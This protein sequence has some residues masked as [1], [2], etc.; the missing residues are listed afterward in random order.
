MPPT[1]GIDEAGRGPI[2]G[3]MVVAG[4][5]LDAEAE[6]SL[7]AMGVR[8]SKRFAG[9]R[10][11]QRRAALA[12]EIRR[13]ARAVAVRV[14]TPAEIDAENIGAIER[15]AA[16]SIVAEVKPVGLVVADGRAVFGPLERKIHGFRAI[17]RAEEAHLAVAAASIV[18]KDARDRLLAEILAR[19]EPDF[20]PIAGGGYPNPRTLA[21][22][23]AY[24]ARFGD[25][26]AEAR[27]K[28]SVS[29]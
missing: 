3:P 26:P 10:A 23:A 21:F 6:I 9:P 19:Y 1:L 13:L 18:A 29:L 12:C 17:D 22:L 7:R 14:V 25:L 20:G 11:R 8:D 2:L 28:W 27:R 16:F 15:R 5:Y 4:V 24:R